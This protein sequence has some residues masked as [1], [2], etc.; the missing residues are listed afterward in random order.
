ME[1]VSEDLRIRDFCERFNHLNRSNGFWYLSM[2]EGTLCILYLFIYEYEI[3][4][5]H[6]ENPAL[7]CGLIRLP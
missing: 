6:P 2:T 7:T 4:R 1:N 5:R 3:T